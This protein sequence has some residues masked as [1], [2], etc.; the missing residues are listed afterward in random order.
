LTSLDIS[1]NDLGRLSGGGWT[2]HPEHADHAK[3]I[4]SDG[5]RHGPNPPEGVEFKAE[6]AIAISNAISAN[7]ALTSLNLASNKLGSEG[8]KHVAEAIK[9]NVSALRFVWWHFE[10]DL[11]SGATAVVYGYSCYN[12]TSQPRW[13]SWIS[14]LIY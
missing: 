12:T 13:R 1:A 2:H 4:H 9:L 3:Y 14:A 8:A 11:T 10:L 7:G 6:G 5:R